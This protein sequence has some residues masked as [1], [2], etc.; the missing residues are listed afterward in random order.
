MQ[1]FWESFSWTGALFGVTS[2]WLIAAMLLI[3]TG[4]KGRQSAA[5]HTASHLT[6][7]FCAKLMFAAISLLTAASLE[8]RGNDKTFWLEYSAAPASRQAFVV[9]IVRAG[10]I[11]FVVKVFM[12]VQSHRAVYNE[13]LVMMTSSF[14]APLIG[15][16]L[17]DV[18]GNYFRLPGA[19]QVH[20]IL[21]L[22]YFRFPGGVLAV[23]AFIL[24]FAFAPTFPACHKE[25]DEASAHH[26]SQCVEEVDHTYISMAV[27]FFFFKAVEFQNLHGFAVQRGP[28]G[29]ETYQEV[30]WTVWAAA[31]FAVFGIVIRIFPE[32]QGMNMFRF[33]SRLWYL[34]QA[35][36]LM[37]A[38]WCVLGS[39]EWSFSSAP[40]HKELY[41]TGFSTPRLFAALS[42]SLIALALV[43]LVG[44][45]KGSTEYFGH[46]Y[47]HAA[48]A[49]E[50]GYCALF[51]AASLAGFAWASCFIHA[52]RDL[53]SL[54]PEHSH[55]VEAS[56]CAALALFLFPFWKIFVLPSPQLESAS[57]PSKP[58]NDQASLARFEK[59]KDEK[60]RTPVREGQCFAGCVGGGSTS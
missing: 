46:R 32:G 8:S 42:G 22:F 50:H 47:S 44:T 9:S 11:F 28:L 24:Y 4:H 53:S 54:F 25:S 51:F 3:H 16:A 34:V 18:L 39:L 15:F 13:R 31:M 33:N 30:G 26:Y 1:D 40:K 19:T 12:Y 43:I 2:L 57:M 45:W 59:K 60:V 41:L 21:W 27:G 52:A 38:N 10:S 37:G 48:A 6:A 58:R 20:H 55:I 23:G 35:S 49:A 56:L 29:S 17:V 5:Q 36:L 7:F 14:G